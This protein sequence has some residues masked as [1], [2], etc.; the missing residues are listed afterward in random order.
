MIA[1]AGGVNSLNFSA[2]TAGITLN[3]AS[4]QAQKI[5]PWGKT[6][7]LQ[8]AFQDLTGTPFA[9]VL[10]GGGYT[11]IIRGDGGNDVLRAGSGNAALVNG[12]GNSTLYGGSGANLLIAGSGT[13]TLYGGSGPSML[14]GGSTNYDANDQALLSLLNNLAASRMLASLCRIPGG[15]QRPHG[16]RP[17]GH[18]HDRRKLRHEEHAGEGIWTDLVRRRPEGPH[19]VTPG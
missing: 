16:R 12:A 15:P 13:S 3:L 5:A 6:L 1:D 17:P 8:G 9:D 14:V 18:G 7:T 2:D 10:T 4:S 11:C 19:E